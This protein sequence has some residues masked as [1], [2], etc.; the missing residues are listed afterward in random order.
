MHS[1]VPDIMLKRPTNCSLTAYFK[2][3]DILLMIPGLGWLSNAALILSDVKSNQVI[4]FHA[5]V[6]DSRNTSSN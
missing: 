5:K 4:L 2:M 1:T 6:N 3:A